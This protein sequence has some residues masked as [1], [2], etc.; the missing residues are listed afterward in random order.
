MN[1][2]LLPFA[3]VAAGVVSASSPCVLPVLPG[4]LAAVSSTERAD[5][6]GR[7]RPSIAGALGFVAGFTIVFTLL[8]SSSSWVCTHS[9]YFGIQALKEQSPE[10]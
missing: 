8:G 5:V 3:A 7:F 10:R 2:A 4:Y 1:G 6:N 9:A